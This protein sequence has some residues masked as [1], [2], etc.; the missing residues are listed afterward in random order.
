M[1]KV[2]DIIE[3]KIRPVLNGHQGDIELVEITA[4][5]VVKVRLTGA[6][7][8]CPGAQQT[9]IEVVET[10]L[11]NFCPQI[12]KVVLVNQ[13]SNDLIKQALKILRKKEA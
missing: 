13:V 6:C 4:D 5:G 10:N 12:K 2:A 9:M 3:T 8:A 11:I 7:A 1:K